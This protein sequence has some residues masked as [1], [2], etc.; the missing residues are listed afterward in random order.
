MRKLRD[1][2]DSYF[3]RSYF[4]SHPEV[5]RIHTIEDML[6]EGRR[7]NPYMSVAN[8]FQHIKGYEL[9]NR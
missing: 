7:V 3:R 5:G 4:Y 9:A 1:V 8:L 2:P 6:R